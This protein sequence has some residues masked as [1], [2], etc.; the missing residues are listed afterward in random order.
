MLQPHAGE[1]RRAELAQMFGAGHSYD[2]RVQRRRN[3]FVE[4]L[5]AAK[6]FAAV[7]I[8]D[9]DCLTDLAACRNFSMQ[10]WESVANVASVS[11]GFEGRDAC[12]EPINRLRF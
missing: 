5:V 1:K 2:T 9:Y 4:T 8:D 3:R 7:F 10:V 11:R 12:R 6:F